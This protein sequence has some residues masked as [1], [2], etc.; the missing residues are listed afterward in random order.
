[1]TKHRILILILSLSLIAL[2][3]VPII[4]IYK[5]TKS[6]SF[7]D[8]TNIKTVDGFGVQLQVID[9]FTFFDNWNIPDENQPL[10]MPIASSA[11]RGQ[12][13]FVIILIA[14]PAVN[15]KNI[16][17]VLADIIVR[18]PDGTI[19]G[20]MKNANIW[21]KKP[22]IKEG[23]FGLGIDYLGINIELDDPLGTYIVEAKV[24]DKNRGL[25]VN[26]ETSFDVLKK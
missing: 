10:H 1:M 18:K 8:K 21:D 20:G 22:K 5:Q 25:T 15:E 9:D 23:T 12:T 4:S 14:N 3:A 19:Y 24:H 7:L 2:I 17:H 26:L 16:C 13:L 11:H 6:H